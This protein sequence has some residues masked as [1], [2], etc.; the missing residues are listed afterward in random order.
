MDAVTDAITKDFNVWLKVKKN[1]TYL[2]ATENN[3]FTEEEYR[4]NVKEF[5]YDVFSIS[6]SYNIKLEDIALAYSSPYP[7]K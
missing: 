1:Y 4:N 6:H 3:T 2:T 7:D 5:L